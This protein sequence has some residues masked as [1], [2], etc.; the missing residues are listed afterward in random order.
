MLFHNIHYQLAN[1][2][3]YSIEST[4][5][6]RSIPFNW[7]LGDGTAPKRG[8]RTTSDQNRFQRPRDHMKG[9]AAWFVHNATK[10]DLR[11]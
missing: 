7:M 4:D 11:E 3:F 5:G 2:A 9:T 1:H 6:D 10:A 8:R